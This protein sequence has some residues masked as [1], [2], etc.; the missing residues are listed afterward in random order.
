MQSSPTNTTLRVIAIFQV[1][2]GIYGIILVMAGLI[3]IRD[4]RIIPMLWFGVFPILISIAGVLLWLRQKH[5]VMIS[6]LIQ[7]AQVPFIR[8][9]GFILNLGVAFNFTISA[10]WLGQNGAGPL[11]L[12]FN[13]LA[14]VVLIILL[15]YRSALQAVKTD[16]S[17]RENVN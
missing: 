9:D 4:G 7:L 2:Y 8:T 12:G 11:V 14:L 5:A 3:G 16:P 13:I 1:I 10:T 15:R 6:I 17:L